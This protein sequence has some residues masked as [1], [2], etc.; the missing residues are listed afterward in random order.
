MVGENRR[1]K[2]QS[3]PGLGHGFFL[4]NANVVNA[5]IIAFLKGGMGRTI[6]V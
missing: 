5:D 4:E 3:Y 1:F 2:S 6:S